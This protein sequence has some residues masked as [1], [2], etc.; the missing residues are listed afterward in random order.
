MSRAAKLSPENHLLGRLS[1]ADYRRLRPKLRHMAF[2][3]GQVVY[4]AGDHIDEVYFPTTSVVSLVNTTEDGSTAEIGLVGNDGIVG[5]PFFLGSQ[6]TSNRAVVQVTG[7]VF[8]MSAIFAKDE[9]ARG[10]KFQELILRY[11][12]ALLTQISQTAICNRLHPTEKRLCR[13]LLLCHDRVNSNQLLMTQ[14][15]ISYMLGGCRESVT[16][17][18]H[19]LQEAGLIHYVRG[20]ITILNRKGLEGAVC[21]CYRIVKQECDR[22]FADSKN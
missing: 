2:S 15:F 6:T 20:R 21:E 7:S 22:L 8:C 5:I 12:H 3:L 1:D 16:V 11:T 17:A 4:E 10:H 18:A 19:H 14:E 13:W 9:F